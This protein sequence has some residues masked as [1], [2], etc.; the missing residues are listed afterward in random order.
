VLCTIGSSRNRDADGR[1]CRKKLAEPIS[2]P[3]FTAFAEAL[4]KD[5]A[6]ENA[7]E[8]RATTLPSSWCALTDQLIGP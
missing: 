6:K 1:A 7:S 2:L 3:L 4:K 5:K 8:P